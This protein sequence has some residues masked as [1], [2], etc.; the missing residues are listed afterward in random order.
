MHAVFLTPPGEF[1]NLL[2]C[3]FPMRK[4]V[5]DGFLFQTELGAKGSEGCVPRDN[6]FAGGGSKFFAVRFFQNT[7]PPIK[8]FEPGA[9]GIGLRGIG[10]R[11]R[12]GKAFGHEARPRGRQPGMRFR[13]AAETFRGPQ[14]LVTDACGRRRF[15]RPGFH[16]VAGRHEKRRCF[17]RLKRF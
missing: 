9:V 5:L 14:P 6:G 17:E 4:N 8:R 10:R 1:R 2:H 12:V 3:R 16:T 13:S 7:E 11:E 15:L